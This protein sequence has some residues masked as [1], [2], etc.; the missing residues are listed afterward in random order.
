MYTLFLLAIKIIPW[1]PVRLMD[2]I[3]RIAGLVAWFV[4]MK[5]REQATQNMLHVLGLQVLDTSQ[6][7]RKLRGIVQAMFCNN[8]LN[9]LTMFSLAGRKPERIMRELHIEGREHF[10]AAFERGKGVI[11]SSAHIGPFNYLFQWVSLSGYDL[12][13]PVE[14]LQDPR[15]LDLITGLR[16]KN[17]T[18]ILPLQGS[19][20]MRTV[21]QKLRTNKAILLTADRAIEGQSSEM[22]FFGDIARLPVGVAQLAKRTGA[23]VVGACGWRTPAGEIYGRFFP[24]SL[25]LSEEQATDPEQIQ[26]AIVTLLEQN[27]TEH[28][29]QWMAFAPIW[30]GRPS[31]ALA[32]THL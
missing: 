13:I 22:T 2:G 19:A 21:F 18:N 4:A 32:M 10:N 16:S 20:S 27:I 29:D 31:R 23:T 25:A 12:T 3:A 7:R 26:Q 17:G 1:L 5:A 11:L 14:P 15:M 6:G 30:A 28:P 24:I 9:Y 8:V